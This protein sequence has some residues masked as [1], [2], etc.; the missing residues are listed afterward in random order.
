VKTIQS[1]DG[2]KIDCVSTHQQPAFDHPLLQGQKPLDPPEIPKGYSEDDGSYENS[3]LWS[4]SG[5]SCPEGTI[6]IRRTTEQDMLRASSVQRF[7]RKIR[8]VKRDSTNN[9]HE[10]STILI[11]II[12]Q[13]VRGFLPFLSSIKKKIENDTKIQLFRNSLHDHY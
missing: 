5:E 9:G 6:P 1:S 12:K 10:V 3:Q 13:K 8:R 2:D 4:L 11:T 7:G